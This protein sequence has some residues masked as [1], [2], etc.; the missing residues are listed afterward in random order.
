MVCPMAMFYVL[1]THYLHKL[2]PYRTKLSTDKNI[3]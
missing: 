3:T 1:S 2:D